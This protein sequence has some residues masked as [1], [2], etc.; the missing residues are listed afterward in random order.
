MVRFGGISGSFGLT[1]ARPNS[2][3]MPSKLA[4]QVRL[5]RNTVSL[6]TKIHLYCNT[7][8]RDREYIQ[9]CVNC[10]EKKFFYPFVS[11]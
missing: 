3:D 1:M 8:S 6:I 2:P 9:A 7:K 11:E 10:G 5:S 4:R